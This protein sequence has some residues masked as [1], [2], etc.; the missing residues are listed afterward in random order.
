LGQGRIVKELNQ[1]PFV[2]ILTPRRR[3]AGD[4]ERNQLVPAYDKPSASEKTWLE[5]PAKNADAESPVG[6]SSAEADR[7]GRAFGPN[8]IA[9]VSAHA[10]ARALEKFW[11]PVPWMLEARSYSNL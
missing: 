7:R 1:R 4:D 5:A 10:F 3:S 8:A 6:L 2:R 11:S 9:D